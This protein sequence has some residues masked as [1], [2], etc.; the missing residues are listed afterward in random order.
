MDSERELSILRALLSPAGARLLQEVQRGYAAGDVLGLSRRLRRDH[1]PELVAAAISQVELRRRARVKL[2]PDAERMY[3]TAE[4]LQQSTRRSVADYRA[5]RLVAHDVHTLLD[6]GCGVGGDLVAAG[7]RGIAVTGVEIDPLRAELARAN[8]AALGLPGTV[9]DGAAEDA[10]RN[11]FDAVFADPARRIGG[12]RPITGRA[13]DPAAYSP[14]WDFVTDLLC[15][16]DGQTACVKVA[17]GIPHE[18]VPHGVEA[19]WVSDEGEL[20]EAALWA[21]RPVEAQRRATLLPTGATLTE[22]DDPGTA[23]VLPVGAVVYEP[24]RAVIRAGLVTAVADLV[25]GGLLDA[26][27]AYVTGP[28]EVTTPFARGYRVLERLPFREKLLRAALRERGVGTLTI[29]KRGVEVT[30]EALRQRLA[31]RGDADATI[32]VTRAAGR[33]TVFLVDPLPNAM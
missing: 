9:V 13:A 24:D 2:G 15:G 25:G 20:K 10:D 27:I 12:R 6:L 14:P 30:P 4:A 18:L 28:R 23:D 17:P 7:A 29:K 33:A 31:L 26:R 1:P 8:L 11:G 16:A 5:S 21:G 32:I 22:A 3:F 19:E